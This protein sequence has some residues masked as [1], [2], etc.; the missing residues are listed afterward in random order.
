MQGGEK[1]EWLDKYLEE[2]CAP[3]TK[4][5]RLLKKQ[6]VPHKRKF[7]SAFSKIRNHIFAHKVAKN[8]DIESE[9]FTK[10][11]V[12]DIDEI[13][14]FLNDVIETIWNLYHNGAKPNLGTKSYDYKQVIRKDTEDALRTPEEQE[15]N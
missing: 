3:S 2:V 6:L 7:D 15:K 8:R 11:A 4:E 12:E 1:P 10:I 9:L 14:Y 5:L 13:L